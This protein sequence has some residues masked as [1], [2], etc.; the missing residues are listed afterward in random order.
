PAKGNAI[1]AE[2]MRRC[3]DLDGRVDGVIN[4]YFDCRAIF[5]VNDGIGESDPWAAKRCPNDVDPAPADASQNACLT[6]GQIETVEFFFSNF[7]SPV[8][9]ANG[10]TSFGMWAPTSTIGNAASLA[11][12]A[13][14]AA[15]ADGARAAGPGGGARA[16]GPPGGA[17]AGGPPGGGARAGGPGGPGGPRAGGP[18]GG[19][20][21]GGPGGAGPGGG[22]GGG[23]LLAG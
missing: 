20:R 2:F 23:G 17:R 16:G 19:R 21:G 7:E 1:L 11:G 6:S 15:P 14:A 5:N 8:E 22:G 3:D 12:A 9:L 4:N 10:R 18:A 13:P